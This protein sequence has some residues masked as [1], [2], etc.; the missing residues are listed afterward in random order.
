M[1]QKLLLPKREPKFGASGVPVTSRDSRKW[2]VSLHLGE[3]GGIHGG[4]Q[5]ELGEKE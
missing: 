1:V 2:P 5:G 4:N 3:E